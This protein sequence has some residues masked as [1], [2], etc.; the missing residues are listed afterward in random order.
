M[1]GF[2]HSPCSTAHGV[3]SSPQSINAWAGSF[4]Q[5]VVLK[6]GCESASPGDSLHRLLVSVLFHGRGFA[7][8]T[9]PQVTRTRLPAGAHAGKP[10]LPSG[11]MVQT[12]LAWTSGPQN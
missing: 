8:L 4:P 10:H 9:S 6:L 12:H 7:V 3:S 5:P 2:S 1:E 11:K